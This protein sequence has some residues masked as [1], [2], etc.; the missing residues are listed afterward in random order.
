MGNATTTVVVAKNASI[1]AQLAHRY[2]LGSTYSDFRSVDSGS[3]MPVQRPPTMLPDSR[4]KLAVYNNKLYFIGVNATTVGLAS[5]DLTG[6]TPAWVV[7]INRDFQ[8]NEASVFF[9]IV[10]SKAFIG[11]TFKQQSDSRAIALTRNL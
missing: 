3:S 10:G 11:A 5:V 6:G 8:G 1:K 2:L 4:R 9:D 7:P